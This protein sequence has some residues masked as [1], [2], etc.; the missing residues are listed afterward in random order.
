MHIRTKGCKEI[1]PNSTTT[2]AVT[3]WHRA[4]KPRTQTQTAAVCSWH[5]KRRL[6]ADWRVQC[7]TACSTAPAACRSVG[8][9]MPAGLW[10]SIQQLQG[11][12]L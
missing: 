5:S 3:L 10:G 11:M 7:H 2:A 6:G 1:T 12:C 8:H 9:K 4:A